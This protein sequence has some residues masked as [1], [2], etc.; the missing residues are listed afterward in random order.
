MNEEGKRNYLIRKAAVCPQRDLMSSLSD[1]L[2]TLTFF[3]SILICVGD[4][5]SLPCTLT[6][7]C[8]TAFFISYVNVNPIDPECMCLY[9]ANL[10]T[11]DQY[12]KL[13][14][15]TDQHSSMR[16]KVCII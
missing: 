1:D 13:V 2:T 9:K 6:R 10:S 14:F 11:R 7:I 12:P 16:V 8:L 5:L 4:D 3:A 15:M